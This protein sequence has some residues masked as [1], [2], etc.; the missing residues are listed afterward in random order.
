MSTQP[1]ARSPLA[2]AVNRT[3]RV[4]LAR[5]NMDRAAAGDPALSLAK[6]AEMVALK[7]DAL[8]RRMSGV[9]DWSLGELLAVA[10]VFGVPLSTITP[11]SLS[12]AVLAPTESEETVS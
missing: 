2:D 4:E 12:D 6:L 8:S 3:I 9:N 7:P 11:D 1:E 10:R 5:L